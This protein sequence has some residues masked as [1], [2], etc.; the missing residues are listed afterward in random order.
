MAI[1]GTA[2]GLLVLVVYPLL[3]I[4]VVVYLARYVEL[5]EGDSAPDPTAGYA[6]HREQSVREPPPGFGAVCRR[7]GTANGSEFRYCRECVARLG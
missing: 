1:D 6:V 2:L 5:G 7:C 3:Q 4:P